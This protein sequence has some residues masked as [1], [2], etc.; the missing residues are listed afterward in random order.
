MRAKMGT[1]E[2]KKKKTVRV[3][4]NETA[5][6]LD[7][8][9]VAAVRAEGEGEG[10]EALER[11]RAECD[12]AREKLR[13]LIQS[14]GIP[15]RTP[16]W[17]QAREGLITAS[18]VAQALG[19]SKFG[20][21]KQFFQKKCGLPDERVPFNAACPPLKWGVMYEPVAQQLYSH[22]NAG[23]FVHEFGLLNHPTVP[24]LG[25]SPDGI[26]EL[27]VMLE[28]KC[29]WRRKIIDKEEVEDAVYA[30]V[31]TQYYYQIQAQLEVCDLDECDYFECE[32]AE[33]PDPV[34]SPEWTEA[35]AEMRGVVFELWRESEPSSYV[36][37]PIA[38]TQEALLQWSAA[39][40]ATAQTLCMNAR[41]HW[42]WLAKHQTVRISRDAEF[43][44]TM[45]EELS[46]IWEQ[47]KSYREDRGSYVE[48]GMVAATKEL[49]SASAS[50]S[51]RGGS[52]A[53]P[54]YAF[55]DA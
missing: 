29:P 28:I 53:M 16:K 4:S 41:P 5:M 9:L 51:K 52:D 1:Q 33:A 23:V 47:V 13:K 14:P 12:V 39:V 21:Q 26:T 54:S 34:A 20:T 45:I 50:S 18:D 7:R 40:E 19:D 44:A 37:A 31:P 3:R 43:V 27:G 38:A 48:D 22:M 8:V 36:Y 25:A 11:R 32:F 2:K 46:G 17:Y 55:R 35:D 49:K 6:A 15:Q 10:S 42:W 30:E 24:F